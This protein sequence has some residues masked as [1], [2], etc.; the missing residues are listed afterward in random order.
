[1]KKTERAPRT[2]KIEAQWEAAA[3]RAITKAKPPT[4][5]PKPE[6]SKRAPTGAP[7]HASRLQPKQQQRPKK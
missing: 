4:G 5:W 2:L 7:K 1:M 3:K 6:S